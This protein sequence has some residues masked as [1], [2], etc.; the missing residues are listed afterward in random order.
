MVFCQVQGPLG[1]PP[2]VGGFRFAP[3]ARGEEGS[4]PSSNYPTGVRW[5][6]LKNLHHVLGHKPE[7]LTCEDVR[8]YLLF[9]CQEK[10]LNSNTR[11][12]AISAFRFLF[13]TT[14]GRE[15]SM[16][17]LPLPRTQTKLPV[18]LSKEE[19]TQFLKAVIEV[20]FRILFMAA[21][22]A[23]LRISEATRL[24]VGDIDSRKMVIHVTPSKGGK[25]RY[26]MLSE[27]LL[28]LLRTYC[29]RA[30]PKTWLFPDSTGENPVSTSRVQRAC[31]EARIRCGIQKHVTPHSLRH[32]FATHLL[33]DGTDLR[34]IQLLLGHAQ[35]T[36][37]AIYTHVAT[38][39]IG[40]VASPLDKLS[41]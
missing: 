11:R 21:Y 15:W 35:L 3:L 36:T 30:Q 19:V 33:E 5:V 22:S 14:L 7:K 6:S 8:V 10:N 34:T 13:W 1:R 26:V 27:R 18:V 39:K 41:L 40:S 31:R 2:V 9:L 23:G 29:Q 24:C 32:S 38:E 37:T 12:Q 25:D 4:T 20:R 17:N 28:Q 16:T